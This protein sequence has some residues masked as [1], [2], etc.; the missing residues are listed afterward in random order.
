MSGVSVSLVGAWSSWCWPPGRER[1][2]P[3]SG[4]GF[5]QGQGQGEGPWPVLGQAQEDLALA[6]GD[7]GRDVQEPVAQCLGLSP[8]QLGLGG[9][10]HRLGQGEQ[11]RSDQGELDLD[12]V[13]VGVP[14]GHVPDAGVLPGSGSGPQL[15]RAR[16]AG[17]GRNAS[18]PRGVL[19]VKAW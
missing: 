19:V 4:E 15:G 6:A 2:L 18:C 13:D 9:Q 3:Q 5:G 16:G 1:D 14:G 10:Q 17:L 8:V 7:A 11:V 12:G